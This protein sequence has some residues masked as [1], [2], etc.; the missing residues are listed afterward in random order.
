M[1]G[2]SPLPAAKNFADHRLQGNPICENI[3]HKRKLTGGKRLCISQSGIVPGTALQA[4][5]EP[6]GARD[7]HI[8][9]DCWCRF[10]ASSR[11][12]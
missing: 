7:E 8:L 9:A 10:D 6:S 11:H 1:P 3:I 5:P 2:G 4:A 12:A